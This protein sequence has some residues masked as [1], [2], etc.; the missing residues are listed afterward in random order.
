VAA[1]RPRHVRIVAGVISAGPQVTADDAEPC[2]TYATRR[3]GE[4]LLRQGPVDR[5]LAQ[6]DVRAILHEVV[7]C[8]EVVVERAVVGGRLLAR[9]VWARGIRRLP[10]R[11]ARARDGFVA[12]VDGW[13]AE[14]IERPL[15]GVV[16][17]LAAL[18]PGERSVERK[19]LPLGR[20]VQAEVVVGV[21]VA[22]LH[23]GGRRGTSGRALAGVRF[24]RN[25]I[26]HVVLGVADVESFLIQRVIRG[27]S[28][29]KTG[30]N[31]FVELRL[32]PDPPRSV[33]HAKW[34][35]GCDPEDLR[36]RVALVGTNEERWNLEIR[37]LLTRAITGEVDA[38]EV[39]G[40]GEEHGAER[41]LVRMSLERP[42]ILELSTASEPR[43]SAQRNADNL[44]RR[45]LRGVAV[46]Q[47]VVLE[48]VHVE[49]V[50]GLRGE[51]RLQ[52]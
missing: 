11:R 36:V 22:D 12:L 1:T 24:E 16:V 10:V 30:A 2:A 13:I 38:P 23:H 37:D 21:D 52:A 49:A 15:A 42:G 46:F 18:H 43:S 50:L 9:G 32:R 34:R 26:L 19:R 6:A 17:D 33:D 29:Q 41:E 44:V 25:F 28:R 7:V 39:I 51:G 47:R 31:R 35:T 20:G 14:L 3:A 40:L 45:T 8:V 27:R 4:P 48:E 5:Q